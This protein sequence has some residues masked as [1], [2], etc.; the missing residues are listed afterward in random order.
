MS[1]NPNPHTEWT[2]LEEAAARL[3]WRG[4]CT[5]NVA[6]IYDGIFDDDDMYPM[7]RASLS[8]GGAPSLDKIPPD[9]REVALSFAAGAA[10]DIAA[11]V[12]IGLRQAK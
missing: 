6:D 9:A 10:M 7:V 11:R 3:V 4:S 2:S 12:I 1:D 5:E 8:L